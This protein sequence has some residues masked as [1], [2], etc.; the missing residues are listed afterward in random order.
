MSRDAFTTV[1]VVALVAY[2]LYIG[3]YVPPM[4]VGSP[5]VTI[6]IGFLLQ[7]VAAIAAAVGVAWHRSWAPLA[8]VILGVAIAVT[9]IIEGFVLGI[10][11]YNHAVAVAVLGLVLTILTA[12]Y[13][14]RGR[15]RVA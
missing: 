12:V 9:E 14:S 5:P 4:L 15:I 13:I 3:S 11:A 8:L 10:I 1:V 7:T 6:L 2:G